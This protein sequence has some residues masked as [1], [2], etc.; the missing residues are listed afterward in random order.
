MY[1]T[2]SL[3]VKKDEHSKCIS[4]EV[5]STHYGHKP[6]VGHLRIPETDRM[7][8][9]AQLACGVNFQHILETIRDNLGKQFH[10]VH[11][12]TRKDINNNERTY[13]LKGAQRHRDDA[14]SVHIW[15]EEM[16]SS[17]CNPVI[18]YKPQGTLQSNICKHLSENDFVLA[19]Q[20]PLQADM[21]KLSTNR[22]NCIDGTHGTNGYD[23]TVMIIDEYGE[24]FPVAWCLSNR[25]DQLLLL[26]FFD[27]LKKE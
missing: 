8:I 13:G 1:C 21:K 10:R 4:V 15:V 14:T 12:L 23:F 6:C 2:A 16:R 27:A 9:A 26:N 11:L 7:A 18:L 22:V 3:I 19:I 24:G 5:H 20:T 17:D 25:E